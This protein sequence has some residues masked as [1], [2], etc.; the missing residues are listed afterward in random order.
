M[1]DALFLCGALADP[2]LCAA[3]AGGV[4]ARMP[5]VLHDHALR[6]DGRAVLEMPVPVPAP[7]QQVSGALVRPDAAARGRITAWHR[8]MGCHARSFRVHTDGGPV[9]ATGW[10]RRLDDDARPW[11]GAQWQRVQAPL[12]VEA[13][14]EILALCASLPRHDLTVR[15]P[16]VLAHA[17]S[18]RTA[19]SA[20]QS[21]ARRVDSLRQRRPYGYFFGVAETDLRFERFDGSLSPVVRRAGFMMSDAVT[22]LPFD[23]VSGLVMLV[24]QFRYGPWLRDDPAPWLLEVIAGR[25]D[26]GET[27]ETAARREA[28]E[29]A[30]LTLRAL[31]PIGGHYPSPGAVTE[32]VHAYVGLTDL[33]LTDEGI[34]GLDSEAE[35]I[36]AHVL[37]LEAALGLTESGQ[38]RNGPTLV[39]LLWLARNRDR[40]CG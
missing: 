35:D 29:E 40:L 20:G 8:A 37:S 5:A 3:V 39:S 33:S 34:A 14:P 10:T 16:M 32:F 30:R 2:Q 21:Q 27:A 31:V 7:G 15:L 36:R 19:R 1:T 11:D 25:I 12:V 28:G 38:I 26:P 23:P 22:V 13:A 9:A 4:G 24:E 17:A 18:R 6:L